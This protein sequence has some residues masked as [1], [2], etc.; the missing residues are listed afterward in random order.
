MKTFYINPATGDIELDGQNK[1][2]MVEGDAELVQ[3]V[4]ETFRTNQG[5][6]FANPEHG[7]LRSVTQTRHYNEDAVR[8]EIYNTAYQDERVENVDR[9]DFEYDK[10]RRKLKVDFEFTKEGGGTVRGNVE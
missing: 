8:E 3:S 7:F 2:R 4:R 5:E 10:A 1:H 9:I 6:W